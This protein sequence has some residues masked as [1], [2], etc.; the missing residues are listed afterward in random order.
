MLTLLL[1]SLLAVDGGAPRPEDGI[2]GK[3]KGT[4]TCVRFPG[5]EACNDEV[6]EYVFERRADGLIVQHAFKDVRGT[7]ESMFDLEPF[8]WDA[9]AQRW[10]ADFQNPRV[11]IR[12]QFKL[13]NGALTG[14]C[15]DLPE[16][17]GVT[18]RTVRVTR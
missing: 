13:E 10:T 17:K 18:R 8:V 4:S 12:W 1:A 6:V 5:N 11:H 16:S 3:W 15:V 7:M 2:L 14:S 9:K